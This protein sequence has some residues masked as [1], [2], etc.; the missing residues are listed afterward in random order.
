M[1]TINNRSAMTDL[2]DFDAVL[3]HG[4]ELELWDL[5]RR[6]SPRQWYV[7][8]NLESPVNRPLID[9]FFEDY[10]NLTMTYRLDSDIV[11]TYATIEDART[12]HLVAP[13]RNNSWTRFYD[14]AGI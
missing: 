10:F 3:F 7:F 12:G 2:T 13:S 1:A 8:V 4:N 11:W 9:Y 6:R 5:P 14:K